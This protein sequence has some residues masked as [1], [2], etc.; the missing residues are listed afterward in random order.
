[1][2]KPVFSTP[3]LLPGS[4]IL[5]P[6]LLLSLSSI[7]PSYLRQGNLKQIIFIS[8]FLISKCEPSK[9][10]ETMMLH[11]EACTSGRAG[12][13]PKLDR[14]RYGSGTLLR[15]LNRR[16]HCDARALLLNVQLGSHA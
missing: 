5:S 13:L 14:Y 12:L 16:L 7:S 6:S 1:M 15:Q 9:E 10:T 3:P 2:L 8:W 11:T 4:G